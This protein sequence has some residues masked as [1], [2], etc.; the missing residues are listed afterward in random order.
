MYIKVLYLFVIKTLDFVI[1][2][3]EVGE[4]KVYK[5]HN[6]EIEARGELIW[7]LKAYNSVIGYMNM[8]RD[9]LFVSSDD[10]MIKM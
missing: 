8:I 4:I 5:I 6:D 1:S 10:Y 3:D 9:S 7:S 2:G